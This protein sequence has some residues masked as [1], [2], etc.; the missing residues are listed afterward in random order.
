MPSVP[1][2]KLSWEHYP[3]AGGLFWWGVKYE[4]R[5][6]L[7]MIEYEVSEC[8][9]WRRAPRQMIADSPDS[10]RISRPII[11]LIRH[12]FG[13]TSKITP[14]SNPGQNE[15]CAVP[16]PPVNGGDD[17]D[18]SACHVTWAVTPGPGEWDVTWESRGRCEDCEGRAEDNTEH[19]GLWREEQQSPDNEP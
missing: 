6:P 11:P 17:N 7:W 19:C 8:E 15:A 4:L 18:G 2:V 12:F 14:L 16:Y 1:A 10:L 9:C 3:D 5:W 13:Q